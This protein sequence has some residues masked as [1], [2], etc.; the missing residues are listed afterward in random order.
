[1]KLYIKQDIAKQLFVYQKH[2]FGI[3]CGLDSCPRLCFYMIN[4]VISYTHKKQ[5]FTVAN[6]KIELYGTCNRLM[7]R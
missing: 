2:L 5:V 1:M 7:N 3:T 6:N 4:A